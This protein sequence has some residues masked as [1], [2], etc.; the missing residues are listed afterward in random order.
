[1]YL[2]A[3]ELVPRWL[4]NYLESSASTKVGNKEQCSSIAKY[5]ILTDHRTDCN[6][7]F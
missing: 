6:T 3:V 2:R 5:I 1:M 4:Q 7:A